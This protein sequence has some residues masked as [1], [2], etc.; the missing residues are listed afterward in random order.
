MIGK[1][2]YL[3]QYNPRIICMYKNCEFC[4]HQN[5]TT[6]Y[7]FGLLKITIYSF[8]FFF[9]SFRLWDSPFSSMRWVLLSIRS[10]MASATVVSPITSYHCLTGSWEVIKVD[11]FPCRSSKISISTARPDWSNGCNPKSSGMGTSCFSILASSLMAEP[12]ALAIFSC[13]RHSYSSC[14]RSLSAADD[15]P[16]WQDSIW[17]HIIYRPAPD[18]TC[19][20]L[21]PV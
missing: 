4:L 13:K 9:S 21:P 16:F 20:L 3:M 18:V 19:A 2:R 15:L 14:G 17:H 12:S 5:R 6:T 1:I 11:L 8:S 7:S 10:S